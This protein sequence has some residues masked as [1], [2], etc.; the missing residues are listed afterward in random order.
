MRDAM[1]DLL[2]RRTGGQLSGTLGELAAQVT[3]AR[4]SY[5][6]ADRDGYQRVASAQHPGDTHRS[7]TSSGPPGMRIPITDLSHMPPVGGLYDSAR[8]GELGDHD[9][10]RELRGLQRRYGPYHVVNINAWYERSW[11]LDDGSTSPA[12]VTFV[13]EIRD[14][15]GSDAGSL[16][17][18]VFRDDD[19]NLVVANELTELQ[20]G[21]TGQGFSTA[22]SASTEDYFRR[23]GV[24]RLQV[25]ASMTDGGVAWAKAGYDWDLTPANLDESVRNMRL[26]IDRFLTGDLGP[27]TQRDAAL[28]RDMRARFEGRVVEFPSPQEL[29]MLAGDNPKLGEKLMRGS[30]WHGMKKL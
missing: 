12:K 30:Y 19:G 9:L 3:A 15:A 6:G 22:F 14:D 21:F 20:K 1:A 27:L 16:L 28:L 13:G 10:T 23:S 4:R 18:S 11:T 24:D 17:Y 2:A 25:T 5:G 8:R 26:R 29:V 7:G